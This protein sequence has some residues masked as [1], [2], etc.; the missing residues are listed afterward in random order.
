MSLSISDSSLCNMPH[1][2]LDRWL[3]EPRQMLTSVGGKDSM[4][5][6]VQFTLQSMS[7]SPIILVLCMQ[8]AFSNF[9]KYSVN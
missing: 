2:L 6:Q 9:I 7:L 8:S 4:H 3:H 1:P 5:M